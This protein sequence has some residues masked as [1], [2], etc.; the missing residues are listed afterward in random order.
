MASV[1]RYRL[2][3]YPGG[4]AA[5]TSLQAAVLRCGSA[6]SRRR[7]T[8]AGVGTTAPRA[9]SRRGRRL[10]VPD[11]SGHVYH[12]FVV[13]SDAPR[14][15]RHGPGA[16]ASRRSCTTLARFIS[17]RRTALRHYDLRERAVLR[18][19]VL[20]LPFIRMSTTTPFVC[21]RSLAEA[22]RVT[23][24]TVVTPCLDPGDRLALVPRNVAARPA[25]TVE[26]L[27]VDGGS[28]DGTVEL[29][30]GPTFG[31]SRSRTPA[32]RDALCK[33]FASR[34][35]RLLTWLNADD[36]LLAGGVGGRRRERR[37][38]GLRRTAMSSRADA[39]RSGVL[40]RTTG[41]GTWLQAR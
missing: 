37:R 15:V 32:R 12:L 34:P 13:R 6:T 9:G 28:T 18:R 36:T 30:E 16:T 19:E 27:V 39:I 25:R 11:V 8:R 41:P 17:I 4:T 20:S 35:G 1:D 7:T 23:L 3:G 2:E 5:S 31:S 21:R 40:C 29:L 24:V 10:P 22:L 38:L 33:G 26:H 14:R